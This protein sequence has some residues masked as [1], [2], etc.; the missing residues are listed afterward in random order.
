MN[1][2]IDFMDPIPLACFLESTNTLDE[3]LEQMIL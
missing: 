1:Y 2:W 3:I